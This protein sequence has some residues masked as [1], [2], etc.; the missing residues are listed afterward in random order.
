[1]TLKARWVTLRARWVTLRARWVTL[2]LSHPRGVYAERVH[3]AGLSRHAKRLNDEIFVDAAD[4]ETKMRQLLAV[5]DRQNFH[6]TM[7]QRMACLDWLHRQCH[8]T[9]H[10]WGLRVDVSA[11]VCHET[12]SLALLATKQI[13]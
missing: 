9:A 6:D 2:P 13:S 10:S 1:V 4:K 3:W 11:P 12:A 7:D 5:M 8:L